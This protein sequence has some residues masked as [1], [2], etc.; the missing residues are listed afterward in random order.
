VETMIV[1]VHELAIDIGG[2]PILVRTDSADFASMLVD[3][4]GEFV[5]PDAPHTDIELEIRLVEPG[6]G[7]GET[8]HGTRDTG[9]GIG[10]TGVGSRE[11]GV[12]IGDSDSF[13]ESSVSEVETSDDPYDADLSVRLESGLWIM[14]RGDF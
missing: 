3:R 5:S 10:E 11:S 12:G 1:T 13:L 7:T 14:E 9:E 8:G 2:I 6:E 4:Y